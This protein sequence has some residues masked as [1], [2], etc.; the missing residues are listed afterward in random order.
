[1][2]WYRQMSSDIEMADPYFAQEIVFYPLASVMDYKKVPNLQYSD[3]I[4]YRVFQP[5]PYSDQ[6]MKAYKS[7]DIWKSFSVWLC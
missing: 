3:M 2:S 7:M 5:S 6:S 1:M 4:N